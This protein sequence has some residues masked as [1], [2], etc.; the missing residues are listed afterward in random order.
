VASFI[1]KENFPNST[2]THFIA[3]VVFDV[4]TFFEVQNEAL[5]PDNNRA[6][7]APLNIRGLKDLK[8]RFIF[9]NDFR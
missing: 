5:L 6:P 3:Q 7:L 2:T 8:E 9:N 1:K 4:I